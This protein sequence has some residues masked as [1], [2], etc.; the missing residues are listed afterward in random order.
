MLLLLYVSMTLFLNSSIERIGI[1]GLVI[2]FRS[3]GCVVL[4]EKTAAM[5]WR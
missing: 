5:M 1:I 4:Y 3:I 2:D